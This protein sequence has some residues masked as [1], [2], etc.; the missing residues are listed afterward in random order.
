MTTR[1][2]LDADRRN[3]N[4]V[5]SSAQRKEELVKELNAERE[6]ERARLRE[7]EAAKT[8]RLRAL[9]LAKEA[10]E[11]ASATPALKGVRVPPGVE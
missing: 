3:R 7:A 5:R 9:R 4:L 6:R 8:A 10:A 2:T 11:A 1:E